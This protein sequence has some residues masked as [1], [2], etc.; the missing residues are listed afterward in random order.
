MKS[1]TSYVNYFSQNTVRLAALTPMF[2]LAVGIAS[3]MT[4]AYASA[5][6]CAQNNGSIVSSD[7]TTYPYGSNPQGAILAVPFTPSS[8]CTLTGAQMMLNSY[9]SPADLH[10]VIYDDSGG[11]PGSAIISGADI[12]SGTVGGSP[13]LYSSAMSGSLSSGTTYWLVIYTSASDANNLYQW[14]N[15][16][17]GTGKWNV[18]AS[19][20]TTSNYIFEIDGSVAPPPPPPPPPGG[21]TIDDAIGVATTSFRQS[22]GFDLDEAT[23]W[24]WDNLGQPILGSG[25]GTLVVMKWYW[26]GFIAIAIAIFFAFGYF[27]FFKK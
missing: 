23:T 9:G 15:S 17:S 19:W 24:M 27:R 25:I 12:P 11:S 7:D 5:A 10:V 22:Y 8:A 13:S 14:S 16:G 21:G 6:V 4:P 20:V 18:S 1:L 26:L 2:V 3:V